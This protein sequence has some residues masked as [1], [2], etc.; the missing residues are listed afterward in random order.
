MLSHSH[1]LPQIKDESIDLVVTSPPYPMIQMRDGLF[2][3]MS[4]EVKK[5]LSGNGDK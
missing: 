2:D 3:S 1:N 5:A 4:D